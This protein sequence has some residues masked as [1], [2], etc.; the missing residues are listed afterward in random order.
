VS[1]AFKY[2]LKVGVFH[3]FQNGTFSSKIGTLIK[4]VLTASINLWVSGWAS[5]SRH[6]SLTSNAI[7]A[8]ASSTVN[9]SFTDLLNTHIRE[10][11]CE[12]R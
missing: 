9:K 7:L 6:P 4:N 3:T 2:A 12:F 1:K 11:I 10:T 5:L 8:I